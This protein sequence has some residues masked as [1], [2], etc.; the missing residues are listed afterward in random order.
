[1][2]SKPTHPQVQVLPPRRGADL[3]REGFARGARDALRVAA[4]QLPPETWP[5]LDALANEYEYDLAGSD[6]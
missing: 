2:H 3:Y 6:G 5:V 1:M 4:R